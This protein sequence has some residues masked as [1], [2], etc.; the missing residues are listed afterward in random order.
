MPPREIIVVGGGFAG[1]YAAWLI[2]KRDRS[3]R[4]TLVEA[5]PRCGG[6]ARQIPYHGGENP[7]LVAGGA[8]IGRLGKDTRLEALLGDVSVPWRP[9]PRR[10]RYLGPNGEVLP[11]TVG[12]ELT[13]TLARLRRAEPKH[14][15]SFRDL[16]V[17]A[18]GPD[19][20]DRFFAL[21]GF[22][23]DIDAD[24]ADTLR[25]Y[26]FDD[27]YDAKPSF[28]MSVPWNR[29]VAAIVRRLRAHPRARV[30][31]STR[32]E[33]LRADQNGIT[34]ATRGAR[35]S[36]ILRGSHVLLALPA[37]GMRALL[38]SM[39]RPARRTLSLLDRVRAQSFLYVYA[40]ARNPAAA[41][42]LVPYYTV[43]T[44]TDSPLQKMIPMRRGVYMIGYA[45]NAKAR[46]AHSMGC[47]ELLRTA[48]RELG[49]REGARLFRGCMKR[50]IPEGTHY[51]APGPS[52]SAELRARIHA[53][54][55]VRVFLAGE[56]LSV[57][58]QGWV[59][60]A[61][62]D[63]EGEVDRMMRARA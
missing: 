24:A 63:A 34:V 49:A 57:G 3:A 43:L 20:K 55:P 60:G 22:G 41:R 46:R 13:V 40:K 18:L 36:S 32:A 44:R 59:E 51:F 23:D 6:R 52:S 54:L 35:G 17:R 47:R 61:L 38:K 58:H 39:G 37:S 2:L 33:R 16:L 10:V 19:G 53:S 5:A 7:P 62:R 30:L 25:M 8:G 28:G 45:D 15:E 21:S 50:W 56:A 26:G 48:D 9:Y 4:V 42:R 1:L 27:N 29:L 11:P 31:T 14:T 12:R